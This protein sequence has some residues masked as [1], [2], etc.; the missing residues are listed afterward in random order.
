MAAGGK[1]GGMKRLRQVAVNEKNIFEWHYLLEGPK[2]TP[3]DGGWYHG[4]LIFPPEYPFAPPGIMMHTPSGRFETNMRLCLS[5]SDYHPESWQP[6]WSVA[7]VLQGLLSFMTGKEMTTGAIE[8][9]D[10]E[11]KALALR[12][13]EHN[14]RNPVFIRMFPDAEERERRRR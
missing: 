1:R 9:S 10:E 13:M 8:T 7:T 3:Y 4:K 14:L 6:S 12:S 11:K 5:M 2:E